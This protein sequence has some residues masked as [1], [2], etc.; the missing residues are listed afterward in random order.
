[1]NWRIFSA[2]SFI[3]CVPLLS[4]I[5]KRVQTGAVAT[6]HSRQGG[7]EQT[8]KKYFVTSDHKNEFDIVF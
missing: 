2:Q 4:G 8:R 7:V 3:V 5:T 6:G 1:M